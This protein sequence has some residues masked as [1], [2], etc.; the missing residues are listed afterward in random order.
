MDGVRAGA[1]DS[2]QAGAVDG[3]WAAQR[4]VAKPEGQADACIRLV[5]GIG[6]DGR[7]PD[8]VRLA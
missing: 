8:D 4:M 6:H 7:C 1:R 3:G 5:Q 2:G